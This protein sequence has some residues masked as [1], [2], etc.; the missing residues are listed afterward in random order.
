M[1]NFSSQPFLD[2]IHS[3]FEKY[4][5]KD[6]FFVIGVSGGSDS[7][8]LLYA[9]HQLNYKA[10]VVH[11]NYNQRGKESDLD[12]ELVEGFA[13]EWGFECCSV[14][15]DFSKS[16]SAENF[17]NWA[18]KQRY[19]V[20]RDLKKEYKA[21]AILTAHHQNDQI[22]TILQK[23]LRGSSLS[24]WQGMKALDNDIFRPLLDFTKQNILSF[25][26]QNAIPFREDES[27]KSSKYARNFIRN[28]LSCKFDSL[29]PGW[30][31]NILELPEKARNFETAI[32]TL[33]SQ[34]YNESKNGI[35]IKA[36]SSFSDNLKPEIMR[37]FL[38]NNDVSISKGLLLESL[39]L[40]KLQTGKE[41]IL[42]SEFTLLKNRDSIV[43]SKRSIDT[44]EN[45]SL[46]KEM[47]NEA[48]NIAHFEISLSVS[49]T[50]SYDLILDA[51]IIKWPLCI[52]KWEKGDVFSPL[53]LHK[54][55]K[56]SKHLTNRK[57]NSAK[58]E[59]SLVLSD[60]VSNIHAIIFP[61]KS[62]NLEW[63]SISEGVKITTH[64]SEF[65]IIKIK[66][67]HEL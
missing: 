16:E 44:F 37:A 15:L 63:G 67:N 3:S 25:C 60:V 39:Q 30:E 21:E 56:V 42:N 46:T 33:L 36:F 27:N 1:H 65:I 9:L 51:S 6:A 64:S 12:Q 24:T 57:V 43:L 52:R 49:Q 11:I 40:V 29:F 34:C 10:I 54:E 38:G 22:E 4:F 58:R 53:G 66:P 8:A 19:Q 61:E 55:Q 50:D 28:E 31:S 13:S 26:T 62:E 23:I 5:P 41:C 35:M 32:Q 17:Q 59:N 7:M 20:F 45:I 2:T 14:S 47:L 48:Q 18:R